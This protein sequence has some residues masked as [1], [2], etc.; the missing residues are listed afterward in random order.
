[1]NSTTINLI[2]SF[3]FV[4]ILIIGF[5]LGFWRGVRRSA[6]SFG[7]GAAGVIV[8]FFVTP[9]ITNAIMQ[10]SVPYENG[11]IALNQYLLEMLLQDQQIA[12]L[13]ENNPN[14]TSLVE[15]LPGAIANVVVFI[16]A[17]ILI[18]LVLYIIYKIIAVTCLKRKEY[19]KMYRTWGGAIGLVKAFI[20]TL[21]VF[22]PVSSLVGLVGEISAQNDIYIKQEIDND[23]Q[24]TLSAAH[25]NEEQDQQNQETSNVLS[26]YIPAEA[27][28]IIDAVNNNFLFKMCGA[29]G[30][31]DAMFDYMSSIDLNGEKLYLRHEIVSYVDVYDVAM[32]ISKIPSSDKTFAQLDFDKL[33]I[34]LGN[35]LDGTLFKQIFTETIAQ[36][37][38]DYQSY[39]DLL[40]QE[41]VEEY[42][43]LFDKISQSLHELQES[44]GEVAEYFTQDINKLFE[45]FKTLSQ[46][47]VLD[48]ITSLTEATAQDIVE[49]L[50][51]NSSALS[52][53]VNSLL[54]MN[55]L[56]DGFDFIVNTALPQ[57]IEGVGE[58]VSDT[59]DW[60]D[61][62]WQ[63]LSTQLTNAITDLSEVLKQV[64]I[65]AVLEDPTSLLSKDD[66]TNIE[67]ALSSLG[68]FVDD[69]LEI[70]VLQDSAGNSI[71]KSL[72]EQNN[73]VL[74]ESSVTNN[75][76]QQIVL[77]S[78]Q[79][80]FE[81]ISQSLQE[82]K[83]NDLYSM[84]TQS[85]D[86]TQIIKEIANLI[87]Q[88]GNQNMLQNIF[89]PLTQVE[90]TQTLIADELVSSLQSDLID[91]TGIEGYDEWNSELGY[92]SQI[93][94]LLNKTDETGTSYL[95]YAING[96]AQALL[97]N[98]GSNISITDILTPVLRAKST[99]GLKEQIVS[100]IE[101]V[102]KSLSNAEFTIS[103]DNIT[104]EEGNK[105]D[106]TSEVCRIF[107]DLLKFYKD[108]TS[109]GG[110]DFN[111][112]SIDKGVL[113]QLLDH[114]KEN[115]YR[116]K[117]YD[118]SQEGL[119]RPVFESLYN[120]LLAEYPLAEDVIG[121]KNVWEISFADLMDAVV[122][123]E[124]AA[125]GS[126][127][128]RV[129]E[130][131]SSSQEIDVSTINDIIDSVTEEEIETIETVL[132]VLDDFQVQI[133][134]VGDSEEIIEQNK[135]EIQEIINSN[136]VLTQEAK[137]K[138]S[139][140][141]GIVSNQGA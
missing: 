120:Q 75:D 39:S 27:I 11:S 48:Q 25:A 92:F 63:E 83:E 10:I 96:D 4:F 49:I 65:S 37:I 72:M 23:G 113:G 103:L 16:I 3:V 102:L 8:A 12:S 2:I 61:A 52:S 38:E 132:G 80:Y 129:G 36:V 60:A 54:Q 41:F 118:C 88:E 117:L 71:F 130:I 31:D 20:I 70:S 114:I 59:A 121:D 21:F 15:A 87:S 28:E 44:A 106:Q 45:I 22:M 125:E 128:N 126:F 115:A 79:Q 107:E 85:S 26:Q 66:T 1:M 58:V 89:L 18:M 34:Y 108:Y 14:L 140:I 69:V 122:E 97:E 100:A 101:E 5:L 91:L 111:F 112:S 43:E 110:G 19:Q 30:L 135:Q 17:T 136:S 93:I 53:S 90:P 139:S 131:I 138:L 33:E 57:L 76:G 77:T 64:D 81:F 124:N 47:G 13:V 29:V 127:I 82:I 105:E 68:K 55:V 46:N 137:D 7:I 51:N 141:L 78:Y 109:S 98:L 56:H 62:Q 50:A 9:L 24:N 73:F 35:V 99:Q 119:F 67:T 74:P 6:V 104:F 94:I 123:I 40:G 133:P 84:L 134:V 32:Q 42:G 116:T 86:A 95:D